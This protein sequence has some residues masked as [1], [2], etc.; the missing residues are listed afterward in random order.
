MTNILLDFKIPLPAIYVA[1]WFGL[2]RLW[3]GALSDEKAYNPKAVKSLAD[4][5]LN[6]PNRNKDI[7]WL[8][9]ILTRFEWIFGKKH[10]SWRCFIASTMVHTLFFTMMCL[11]L[12]VIHEDKVLLKDS[13]HGPIMYRNWYIIRQMLLEYFTTGILIHYFSLWV[14]RWILKKIDKKSVLVSF[15]YMVFDLILTTLIGF[16]GILI[17]MV[18]LF[19]L[20]GWYSPGITEYIRLNYWILLIDFLK[21]LDIVN[22]IRGYYFAA[23]LVW[24]CLI[25]SLWIWVY[26]GTGVVIRG[27]NF[28]NKTVFKASKDIF[29]V[30]K[31]PVASIRS[32]GA[33]LISFIGLA[34]LLA[35]YFF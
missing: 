9:M 2:G 21:P 26:F 30:D 17:T 7:S 29:Q 19:Y 5:L 15:F 10:W 1:V 33:W 18:V 12:Y 14:T 22:N 25:T 4:F 13:V 20:E 6:R 32:I 35:L 31:D 8:S 24:S 3:V 11:L 23:A 34:G 28:V 16:H 27:I